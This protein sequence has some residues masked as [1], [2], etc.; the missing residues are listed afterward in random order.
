M[1][2]IVKARSFLK[3]KSKKLSF[4][5][6]LAALAA[7][8]LASQAAPAGAIQWSQLVNCPSGGLGVTLSNGVFWCNA[9]GSGGISAL[10]GDVNASGTGSVAATVVSIG[11]KTVSLGGT[12][13]ISGA[14]NTTI[15][16]TGATNVTFP[17]SGTLATTAGI[18][19]AIN[20]ALPSVSVGTPY[21]GSGGA[22]VAQ[23]M[24]N[25]QLT[26]FVN[27]FS[28]SLSGAA[29][30]SGGGTTTFLRA[31]GTWATP[32][33]TGGGIT[34]ITG[35]GTAGPGSG[36]QALTVS[37][38]GGVP[39]SFGG[40]FT[41]SGAFTVTQTYTGNTSVTFPTTGTLINTTAIPSAGGT[42]LYVGSGAAG[43][44]TALSAS[45][46]GTTNFLRADMTWA[47]AGGGP[48]ATGTGT[49]SVLCNGGTGGANT[50]GSTNSGVFGGTSNTID[51]NL[52]TNSVIIGGTTNSFASQA[53]GYLN[54]AII[55]GAS[56]VFGSSGSNGPGSNSIIAGGTGNNMGTG[57]SNN[58]I[59]AGAS[60]TITNYAASY[61][62]LFGQSNHIA[63][64]GHSFLA[65]QSNT[66]NC[67]GDTAFGNTNTVSVAY[68][69][70]AGGSNATG[71][72]CGNTGNFA[73]GY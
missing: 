69:F 54:S 51:A 48:C 43:A 36:S 58:F 15:T 14:F 65:G 67:D 18:T 3:E 6:S 21:G 39:I 64:N 59:G 63:N 13:T 56:N 68:G 33:G 23:A 17:T 1:V 46:G 26:A 29:P 25:A 72:G 30:A 66:T 24:T 37:K 62:A 38:I 70:V 40:S 8:P 60:N 47:A 22:G 44:A 50:A 10:T 28:A 49:T 53:S 19:S 73:I 42:Q 27:A 61:S 9:I 2:R 32:P 55:G 20:T 35:D 16:V 31:D 11:G 45:G 7:W 41:T 71:G 5:L 12:F 34:Q 4:V 52:E 57:N